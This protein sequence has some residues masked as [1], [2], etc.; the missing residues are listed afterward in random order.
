[1]SKL[2]EL[3][4]SIP[5]YNEEGNVL[6][7]I[8]S[9]SGVLKKNKIDFEIIAL[10]NGSTDNTG[11]ILDKIK[12]PR[13]RVFHIKKNKGYGNGII[14]CLKHV[15]ANFVGH[16]WGDNEIPAYSVMQIYRKLL[17]EDLDLCKIKR[18][19]RDYN[20]IRR[21]Q[22]RIF[23]KI[24]LRVLFG[25][26]PDDINGCPKIMRYKLYKKLDLSSRDA[27]IDTEIILKAKGYG[28]KMGNVVVNYSKRK[29]GKSKV[30]FY[31]FLEFIK[32]ILKYKIRKI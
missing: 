18:Y 5:F 19:L 24:V 8:K 14:E 22:S 10:D 15:K 16:M 11:I 9:L 32:N 23:N 27:F 28:A 20:F 17:N 3:S 30:K 29:E 1:M 25:K 2:V 13:I 12:D 4:I 26:L 6:D 31:I 7:V 21:V